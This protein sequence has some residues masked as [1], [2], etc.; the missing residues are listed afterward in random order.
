MTTGVEIER[1]FLL[2]M[3]VDAILTRFAANYLDR[4]EIE[5]RYLLDTGGW[6]MRVRYSKMSDVGW[7]SYYLT[8]KRKI[9]DEKCVELETDIDSRTA[10]LWLEHCDPRCIRKDRVTLGFGGRRWSFDK[11]LNPELHGLEMAEVE[12]EHEGQELDLL[13][14]LSTEVT[15]DPQYRNF[16]LMQRI[17]AL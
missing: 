12:L 11:F 6:T 1:K 17:R 2:A 4:E 15:N 5:Q 13:P 16:N 9:S 7:A 8:L 14:F 10:H 3:S